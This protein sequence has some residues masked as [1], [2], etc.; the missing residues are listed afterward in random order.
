MFKAFETKIICCPIDFG[1][2]IIAF[3]CCKKAPNSTEKKSIQSFLVFVVFY[4]TILLMEDFTIRTR[5][6]D[7]F[8]ELDEGVSEVPRRNNRDEKSSKNR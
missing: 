6:L 8:L 7:D 2:Q 5:T 1:E 4:S 3:L